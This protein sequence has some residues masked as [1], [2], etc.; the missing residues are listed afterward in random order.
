MRR[1]V[2][3]G[4]FLKDLPTFLTNFKSQ[5]QK[6]WVVSFNQQESISYK[7]QL[8]EGE[9]A[10]TPFPWLPAVTIFF[11]DLSI[12]NFSHK[13]SGKQERNRWKAIFTWATLSLWE[14]L[15]AKRWCYKKL[16]ATKSNARALGTFVS[17]SLSAPGW[18]KEVPFSSFRKKLK[19]RSEMIWFSS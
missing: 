6:Q 11:T 13:L 1:M 2:C 18:R 12:A 19:L 4:F 17:C 9:D 7:R 8:P 5:L 15:P 10:Q 14:P 3:L 16:W